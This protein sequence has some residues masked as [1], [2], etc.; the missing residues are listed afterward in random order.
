MDNQILLKTDRINEFKLC[1]CQDNR[2][3]RRNVTCHS[4]KLDLY[5]KLNNLSKDNVKHSIHIGYLISKNTF[6]DITMIKVKGY[7]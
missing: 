3:T 5:I 1:V 4:N 2:P 6:D 7:Y